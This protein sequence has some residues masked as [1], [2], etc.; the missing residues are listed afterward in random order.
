MAGRHDEDHL[1]AKERLEN[2]PAV[3][4]RSA[5]D[6]EL[7]LAFRHL[8]DHPVRIRDRQGD[9]QLGVPALELAEQHRDD[10]ATRSGRG[11]ERELTAKHAL[12]ACELLEQLP[13]ER[14]HPLRGPVEALPRL[15]RLD[16]AAGAVE[17]PLLFDDWN[18]FNKSD[19]MG[20]RLAFR[21]FFAQHPG[22]RAEPF[23]TF[24]W[25]GQA[26]IMKKSAKLL[27]QAAASTARTSSPYRSSFVGPTPGTAASSESVLG[28]R[29]AIC[30]SVE[31]WK[32]T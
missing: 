1:V 7:E 4:R 12:V 31:L 3:A 14:K 21:E 15:G 20:E 18:C 26:F 25:H 29:S 17:Q 16:P 28:P 23:I 10:R 24:G 11:A 30:S 2:D 13:F 8:L 22:W 5:D 9:A 6:P 19:E 27:G 32:T